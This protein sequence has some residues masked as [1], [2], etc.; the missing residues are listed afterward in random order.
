M[1]DG[2]TAIP[3]RVVDGLSLS[4]EAARLK[5][6]YGIALT[7]CYVLALSRLEGC[8]AIFRKREKILEEIEEDFEVIFLEDYVRH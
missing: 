2:F 4:V 5:L 7:D 8:K 3:Q 1:W 6:K